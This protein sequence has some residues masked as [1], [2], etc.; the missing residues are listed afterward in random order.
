M[1]NIMARKVIGLC[2]FIGS[3]KGS[4][5]DIL[6]T[7]YGYTK[8]NFADTLKDGVS[9]IFGWDRL[10]LEGDTKESRDWRETPDEFWSEEL[11]RDITP[12]GVMQ[13]FGTE[14]MRKGFDEEV[15]VLTVKRQIKENP[16]INYVITDVR[17]Y[18]ERDMI[19]ELGGEV[20]RVKRGP[21]PEWTQKAINDNKYDTEWMKDYPDIHSSEW[22]W[23]DHPTEFSRTI[24]NDNDLSALTGVVSRA[25][26]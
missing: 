3:G 11:H 2:G 1:D 13:L 23:L 12:R 8:L 20:W 9:V 5:G 6:V 22:R 7:D 19:T 25:I 24:L 4:V 17:F 14:C 18:N 21:D 26:S 10:L 16:T 15:W